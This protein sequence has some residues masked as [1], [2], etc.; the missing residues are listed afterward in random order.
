MPRINWP[1]FRRRKASQQIV[2]EHCK[3]VLHK[4]KNGRY[5][6]K[7]PFCLHTDA[8]GGEIHIVRVVY[9]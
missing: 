4:K 2:C 3:E 1:R 6:R 7:C 8:Y 5:P 9:V